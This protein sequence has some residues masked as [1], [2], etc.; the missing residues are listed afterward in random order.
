MF[1]LTPDLSQGEPLSCCDILGTVGKTP[2]W[3]SLYIPPTH[4]RD[5]TSYLIILYLLLN[6]GSFTEY[7][8][9]K[10]RS[11]SKVGVKSWSGL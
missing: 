7:Y 2:E 11:V 4:H 1:N 6:N 9:L 5:E 3:Y 8:F 10:C